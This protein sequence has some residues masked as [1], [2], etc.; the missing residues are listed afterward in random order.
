MSNTYLRAGAF[1]GKDGQNTGAVA[2]GAG[3]D[4]VPSCLPKPSTLNPT[5]RAGQDQVSS[6]L[7]KP[8]TLNPKPRAGQDQVSSCLPPP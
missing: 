2:E 5:P 3:Q 7:P 8:S 1:V 4:Q 6:C